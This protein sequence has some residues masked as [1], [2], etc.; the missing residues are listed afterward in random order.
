MGQYLF[1]ILVLSRL[2]YRSNDL[3]DFILLVFCM[4]PRQNR[5]RNEN[6][7]YQ[8]LSFQHQK[9]SWHAKLSQ[10]GLIT[11]S[12]Y[13]SPFSINYGLSHERPNILSL[14]DTLPPLSSTIVPPKIFQTPLPDGRRFL[15]HAHPSCED[16][17]LCALSLLRPL[18]VSVE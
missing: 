10:R 14:Y 12:D 6:S 13:E 5:G 4:T 2:L 3:F 17:P 16:Q 7:A 8:Q 1:N 9:S 15:L 18:P 11:S